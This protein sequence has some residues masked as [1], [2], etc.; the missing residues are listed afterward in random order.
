MLR[1]SVGYHWADQLLVS[2]QTVL[3]LC[4]FDEG[5]QIKLGL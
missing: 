5:N 1:Q 4:W 2:Q 3:I